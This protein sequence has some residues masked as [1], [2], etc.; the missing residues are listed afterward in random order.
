MTGTE[1]KL[2][3]KNSKPAEPPTPNPAAVALEPK[4]REVVSW[5]PRASL[6]DRHHILDRVLD[7]VVGVPFSPAGHEHNAVT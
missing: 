3:A 5:L 2:M 1:R 4:V 7:R 6:G